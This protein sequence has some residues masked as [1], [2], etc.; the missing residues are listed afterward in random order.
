LSGG[1]EVGIVGE[2]GEV[3]YDGTDVGGVSAIDDIDAEEFIFF[4]VGALGDFVESGGEGGV[5][6]GLGGGK[7]IG[8][9][10]AGRGGDDDGGESGSIGLIFSREIGERG[11]W[12]FGAEEN[13]E[14][15][16]GSGDG[17]EDN[18][19]SDGFDVVKFV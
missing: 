13:S 5:K 7:G 14:G 11:E 9:L 15:D 6:G 19:T 18:A 2:G 12:V 16:D 4:V 10:G 8:C 1:S 3:F 17:K